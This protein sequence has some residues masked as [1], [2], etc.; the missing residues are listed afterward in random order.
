MKKVVLLGVELRDNE[1]TKLEKVG[2]ELAFQKT[3]TSVDDLLAKTKGADA[4][5]SNGNFL[6]ESLAK[7]ENVFVTYPY[8]ELGEFSSAELAKRG[9]YVA[10]ARGG[11]KNSIVEWVS[12]MALALFRGFLSEIRIT[13]TT[14]FERTKSLEGRRALI[15]G[16]GDIGSEIGRRLS[17]FGMEVDFLNRGD[18]PIAKSKDADLVVNALNVNRS[19]KNLLDEGFFANLKTGAYFV[20]FARRYTYDLT[21]LISAINA[22]TVAGAAIDCDPEAFGSVDNDFYQTAFACDKILVT[23]HI[24][25][26]SDIAASRGNEI[27]IENI[28]SFLN[29]TPKNIVEK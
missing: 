2:A 20:S 23:P 10:N 21:G 5:Y 22:G 17:E 24:A 3:P 28:L 25:A 4:I 9:V 15:V 7:L 19:S 18:D 1:K 8:I 13:E 14:Q 6:L 16:H 11:N 26:M 27:A 29:G 12:F